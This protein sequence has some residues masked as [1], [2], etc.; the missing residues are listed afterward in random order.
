MFTDPFRARFPLRN[1]QA[2]K[3]CIHRVRVESVME[4]NGRKPIEAERSRSLPHR[5]IIKLRSHEIIDHNNG[6]V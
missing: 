6:E 1:G 2:R 4:D 3:R 5:A